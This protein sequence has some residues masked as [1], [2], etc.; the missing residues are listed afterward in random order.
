VA[1]A[2]ADNDDGEYQSYFADRDQHLHG[3]ADFHAEIIQS[4]QTQDK[5]HGQYLALIDFKRA[6]GRA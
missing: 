4:A 2:Q 3:A 1:R 6:T 5:R